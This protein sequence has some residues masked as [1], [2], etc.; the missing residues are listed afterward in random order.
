MRRNKIGFTLVELLVVMAIISILAAML[1]PALSRARAQA[2]SVACRSNLK[3]I[4][5]STGMYQTDYDEL[6]P[7]GNN[8]SFPFDIVSGWHLYSGTDVGDSVYAHPLQI[9]AYHG[10]AK[11]GWHGNNDRITESVFTCPSDRAAANNIPDRLNK[12]RCIRAHCAGGLTISY[13]T[14]QQL[15]A[16]WFGPYRDWARLASRPGATAWVVEYDW[17]NYWKVSWWSA[18]G[19][20]FRYKGN[21]DSKTLHERNNAYAALLRHGSDSANVLWLDL[22]VAQKYAFAWNSV[23]AFCRY[24]SNGDSQPMYSE[25]QYFHCPMGHM[26]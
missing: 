11:V 8:V 5:Y 2:R 26:M 4:G 1:L 25:A 16:N 10:Y 7:S 14:N 18:F 9:L 15:A 17:W 12:K 24:K 21:N 22:H 20:N 13:T 19:G 23:S 3:Q 6:C